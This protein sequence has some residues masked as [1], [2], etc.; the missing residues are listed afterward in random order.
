MARIFDLAVAAFLMLAL[1]VYL[2][3]IFAR[4]RREKP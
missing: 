3:I 4:S 2:G 1:I